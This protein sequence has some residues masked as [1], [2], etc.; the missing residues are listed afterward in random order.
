MMTP[1]IL[2]VIL[3]FLILSSAFLAESP[4]NIPAPGCAGGGCHSMQEGIVS[5][6]QLSNLQVQVDISGVK[7][8][9][10]IA[11]ELVD[12][13]NNIVDVIHSTENNPFLLTA[14]QNGEYTVNAGYKDPSLNWGTTSINLSPNSISIPTPNN[15]LSSFELFPN[16]P[17]PFNNETV[18]KFSTP[19][20]ARVEVDI[21][22]IHGKH[23]RHLSNDY[24]RAGIHSLR[25]DGRD[26]DGLP[27]SSGMYLSQIK[28]GDQRDVRSMI[29]SK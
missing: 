28:S 7:S 18:I 22:N 14:P 3:M 5:A 11:A 12:S 13:K 6:T 10:K 4:S 26:D 20:E 1:K 17:N 24:Y 21:F 16:H 25:W 9:K 23:I 29:L 27:V 2:I 15:S 19:K 8:G